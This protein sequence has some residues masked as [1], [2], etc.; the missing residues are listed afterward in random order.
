MQTL[1][2]QHLDVVPESKADQ[3]TETQLIISQRTFDCEQ[4]VQ[5][6]AQKLC[7]DSQ[8]EYRHC[9]DYD[10]KLVHVNTIHHMFCALPSF[11]FFFFEVCPLY[12]DIICQAVIKIGAVGMLENSGKPSLYLANCV[13]LW[14]IVTDQ[15][16]LIE[17]SEHA[18]LEPVESFKE[19]PQIEVPKINCKKVF[20]M[21]YRRHHKT[22]LKLRDYNNCYEIYMDDTCKL[23]GY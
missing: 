12:G 19:L 22:K 20:V 2:E 17:S 18:K 3:I 6:R 13:F 23:V 8:L 1:N 10:I 15:F 11:F 21:S 16:Q 7:I 4:F 14:N 9:E 5:R